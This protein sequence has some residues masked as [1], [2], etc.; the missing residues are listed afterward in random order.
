MF[1]E[2]VSLCS[3][4]VRSF[5]S[6]RRHLVLSRDEMTYYTNH[7]TTVFHITKVCSYI[8][9]SYTVSCRKAI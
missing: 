8:Q 1:N 7:M 4:N 5:V 2:F 9:Y 3:V 6:T